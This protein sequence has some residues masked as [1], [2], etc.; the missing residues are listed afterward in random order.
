MTQQQLVCGRRIRAPDEVKK[1]AGIIAAYIVP[2]QILPKYHK[3]Y[4]YSLTNQII[5][6]Q[7]LPYQDF[8]QNSPQ[9]Q[10]I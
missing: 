1:A 3:Q 5:L 2:R 9:Q 8:R 10:N 4:S 6:L 7:E